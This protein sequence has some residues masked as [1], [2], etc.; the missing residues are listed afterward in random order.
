MHLY[1]IP[2]IYFSWSVFYLQ[3]MNVF[4]PVFLN[5]SLILLHSQSFFTAFFSSC[6]ISSFV[7]KAISFSP[8][9]QHFTF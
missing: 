6:R 5:H 8:V 4:L 9:Y 1:M 7:I 2:I 3:I